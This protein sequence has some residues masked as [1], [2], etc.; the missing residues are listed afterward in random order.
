MNETIALSNGCFI[1]TDEAVNKLKVHCCLDK[2][3]E[4]CLTKRAG[5]VG[6]KIIRSLD[7]FLKSVL[8]QDLTDKVINMF[9]SLESLL[10]LGA[11]PLTSH[12]DD[13]AENIALM[14]AKD[15]E[16]R[17]TIK[18][19]FKKKIYKLRNKI[20]HHGENC[21]WEKDGREIFF[22]EIIFAR[23]VIGILKRLDRILV[24]GNKVGAMHEYFE[25]EKLK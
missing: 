20:M 11:D 21:T 3:N 5:E 10:S 16:E 7:W 6:E 13:M 8:E 17:Y 19:D 23:S 14:M 15:V 22:L 1:L 4:I 12:T 25:R 18:K 24:Y 9:I 2:Y